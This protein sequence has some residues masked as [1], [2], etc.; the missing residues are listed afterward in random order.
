MEEGGPALEPSLSS[1][2]P[3]TAWPAISYCASVPFV[4]DKVSWGGGSN[5]TLVEEAA[6]TTPCSHGSLPKSASFAFSSALSK[7]GIQLFPNATSA[8]SRVHQKADTR[9]LDVDSIIAGL[10]LPSAE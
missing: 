2:S 9:T 3:P 5:S 1:P 10:L 8:G 7:A 6:P 4:P